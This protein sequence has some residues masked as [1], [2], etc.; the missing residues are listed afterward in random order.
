MNLIR[1]NRDNFAYQEFLDYLFTL[2][3]ETYRLFHLKLLK[4]ND[5]KNIGIRTPILKKIAKEISKG[6]YL[7]FIN[8]I[9]HELYEEDVIYGYI[10]ENIKGDL[11]Y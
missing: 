2:S 1:S 3:D 8:S 5:I 4:N 7:S 11:E 9:K 10:L 6:N